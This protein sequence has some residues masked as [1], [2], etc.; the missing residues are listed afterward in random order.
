MPLG[1]ESAGRKRADLDG[2]GKAD[3]LLWTGHGYIVLM[4]A[5]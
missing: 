2:N 5:P 3:T 1:I 4:E